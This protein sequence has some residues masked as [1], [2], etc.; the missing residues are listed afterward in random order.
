MSGSCQLPYSRGWEVKMVQGDPV[1]IKITYAAD[2]KTCE[3]KLMERGG[4][5]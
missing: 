3:K 1:N 2:L 4:A 5:G